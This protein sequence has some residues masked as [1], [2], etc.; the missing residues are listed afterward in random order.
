[1]G[2]SQY[3][4]MESEYISVEKKSKGQKEPGVNHQ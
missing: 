3:E 4:Q 2:Q 1:M